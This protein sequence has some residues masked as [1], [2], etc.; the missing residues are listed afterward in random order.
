MNGSIAD[1]FDNIG[2]DTVEKNKINLKEDGG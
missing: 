1:N 2:E